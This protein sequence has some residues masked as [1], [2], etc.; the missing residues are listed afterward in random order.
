MG[1]NKL[2]KFYKLATNFRNVSGNPLNSLFR[3]SLSKK[4]CFWSIIDDNDPK[5]FK[6]IEIKA[7]PIKLIS[8]YKFSRILI[9]YYQQKENPH[10]IEI[11]KTGTK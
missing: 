10:Q 6:S 8:K 1:H 5:A 2:S 4:K 9:I 11:I 3:K 7:K